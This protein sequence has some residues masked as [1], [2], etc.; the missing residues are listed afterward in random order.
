MNPEKNKMKIISAQYPVLEPVE[1]ELKGNEPGILVLPEGSWDVVN[2]LKFED[3]LAATLDYRVSVVG[4][5]KEREEFDVAYFLRGGKAEPAAIYPHDG[6]EQNATIRDLCLRFNR[7][8]DISPTRDS[9]LSIIKQCSEIYSPL[10]SEDKVDLMCVP[11]SIDH[12][13]YSSGRALLLDVNRRNI[14]E[15]SLL[16]QAVLHQSEGT[17]VFQLPDFKKLGRKVDGYSVY[18]L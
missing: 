12:T 3:F 13:I 11:S 4:T 2:G 5:R 14:G 15:N 17:G 8:H 9:V 1:R 10:A 6:A 7:V 18:Q 16:V